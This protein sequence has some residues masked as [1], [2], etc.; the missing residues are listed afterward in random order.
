MGLRVLD[1]RA[2]APTACIDT[3]PDCTP[4]AITVRNHRFCVIGLEPIA[5]ILS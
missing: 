3:G 1:H 4:N 5:I 2:T